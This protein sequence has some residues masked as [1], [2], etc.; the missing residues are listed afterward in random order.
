MKYIHQHK[1]KII[2]GSLRC[3]A[4]LN[5]LNKVNAPKTIWIAEDA[6]GVIQKVVYDVAS[7]QLIGIVLPFNQKGMPITFTFKVESID[8][9]ERFMKKPMST[10]VYLV[11]AQPI[12]EKTPP[13]LLQVFGSDN[14]FNSEDVINRW[15]HTKSELK[16]YVP[17]NK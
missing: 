9:I 8:D 12:K 13:F 16:K 14:K 1:T 10:H 4:L 15:E 11:M 2:E 7:R 17:A 3:E 5:Y 6:T